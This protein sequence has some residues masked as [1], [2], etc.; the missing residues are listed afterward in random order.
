MEPQDL[1]REIARRL[2]DAVPELEG[3]LLFGS[4]ARGESHADSDVDLLLLLPRTL[5][6]DTALLRARK[7]LRHLGVGFD[8]LLLT[9]REWDQLRQERSAF[10]RDLVR[11]VRSLDAS[12]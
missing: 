10:A 12:A 2:R 3:I 11:D 9:A 5:D 1:Y 4:R 7:S 6:R 8:L